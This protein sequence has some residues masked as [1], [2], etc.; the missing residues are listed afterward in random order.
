MFVKGMPKVGGR[1]RGTSNRLTATF[2]QAVLLAYQRIGGHEAFTKWAAENRSDFYRIAARLIPIENKNS[3]SEGLT[4]IIN[5]TEMGSERTKDT[6]IARSP[7]A[8]PTMD[9][10]RTLPCGDGT[11]ASR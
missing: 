6:A 1:R 2:R 3:D 4:V 7:T 11:Y 10:M 9:A 5:R 8:I